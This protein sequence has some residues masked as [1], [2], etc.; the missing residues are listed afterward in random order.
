MIQYDVLLQQPCKSSLALACYYCHVKWSDDVD[1]VTQLF[2]SMEIALYDINTPNN[3]PI[4]VNNG[5]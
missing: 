5:I 3:P 2:G 1:N 4:Y